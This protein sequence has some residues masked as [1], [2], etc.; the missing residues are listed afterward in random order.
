MTRLAAALALL[1]LSLTARAA[2]EA[3]KAPSGEDPMAGW[4]PPRVARE[5]QDRKE[6]QALLKAMDDAGNA[7]DVDA[8]AAL[9]DYPVPMVNHDAKGQ[10]TAQ[11]WS[12]E[13]WVK[14][15]QPFFKPHP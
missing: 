10:A 1:T 14:V 5:A 9:L 6:I 8:A 12:K 3:A 11:P 13:Q 2:D 15:M 7:G 4:A